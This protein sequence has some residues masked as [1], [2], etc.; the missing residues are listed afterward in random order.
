MLLWPAITVKQLAHFFRGTPEVTHSVPVCNKEQNLSLSCSILQ[1]TLW[2]PFL[3]QICFPFLPCTSTSDH[4]VV[5]FFVNHLSLSVLLL[6]L[7]VLIPVTLI[8]PLQHCPLF[9][10]SLPISPWVDPCEISRSAAGAT[11]YFCSCD[12]DRN[13]SKLISLFKSPTLSTQCHSLLSAQTVVCSILSS[14]L[15]IYDFV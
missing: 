14:F 8:S 5:F 7:S 13:C 10:L 2:S 9:H 1:N 15:I 11:V 12:I 4:F 6:S 3:P